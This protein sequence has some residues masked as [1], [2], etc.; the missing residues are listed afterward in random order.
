MRK[1][2]RHIYI[3]IHAFFLHKQIFWVYTAEGID[4]FVY[5]MNLFI[6]RTKHKIYIDQAQIQTDRQT[7]P[8]KYLYIS[9]TKNALTVL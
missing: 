5:L 8:Y 3:Y 2:Q 9:W 1:E 6:H 7:D 4:V